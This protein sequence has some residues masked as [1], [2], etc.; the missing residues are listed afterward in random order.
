MFLLAKIRTKNA[1]DSTSKAIKPYNQ[2]PRRSSVTAPAAEE[3]SPPVPELLLDTSNE[4]WLRD[5][6]QPTINLNSITTS[7]IGKNSRKEVKQQPIRPG[8]IRH[9]DQESPSFARGQYRAKEHAPTSGNH[10]QRRKLY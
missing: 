2:L 9:L 3:K 4:D 1:A 10:H 6:P 7:I 5:T 8:L